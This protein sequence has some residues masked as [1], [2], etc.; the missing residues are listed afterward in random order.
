LVVEILVAGAGGSAA[1]YGTFVGICGD[2]PCLGGA[3]AAMGVELVATPLLAYGTGRLMGGK[4]TFLATLTIGLLGFTATTPL[5]IE[6]PNLALVIS[7]AVMPILAPIGFELSSSVRSREMRA[8][9]GIGKL[10]P[11]VVPVFRGSDVTGAVIGLG[12]S[13]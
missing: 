13:F 8:Q 4:G 10:T 9:L 7:F 1:G 5:S 3:L 2:K 12:A 11:M 6:N